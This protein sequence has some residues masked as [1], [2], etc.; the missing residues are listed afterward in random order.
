MFQSSLQPPESAA[1]Q[2]PRWSKAGGK[3]LPGLVC[4]REAERVLFLE[5]A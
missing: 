2:F 3:V 5:A 4:R 1:E